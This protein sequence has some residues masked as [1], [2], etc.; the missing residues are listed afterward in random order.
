ME[1]FLVVFGLAIYFIPAINA[2][3]RKHQSAG[4]IFLL[5]IF[6]GWTLVGWVIALVWSATSVIRPPGTTVSAA[7]L[8]P[9]ATPEEAQRRWLEAAESATKT[10]PF[11]P[12]T[13]KK[14]A[15]KCRF[16][17]SELSTANSH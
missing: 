5:N 10:C 17:G 1:I 2:L 9:S 7:D 14:R 6:L 13:I 3:S 16:C 11:C 15:V 4:A 12:E 8:P